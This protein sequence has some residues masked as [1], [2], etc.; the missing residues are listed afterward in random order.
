MKWSTCVVAFSLT[1]A[2]VSHSA[3]VS[4]EL[5]DSTQGI[6]CDSE[7]AQSERLE[8]LLFDDVPSLMEDCGIGGLFNLCDML[9][10]FGGVV[11]DFLGNRCGGGG[12]GRGNSL[13]CDWGF[14][15]ESA[16][17][18]YRLFGYQSNDDKKDSFITQ[19]ANSENQSTLVAR[20]LAVLGVTPDKDDA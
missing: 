18:A 10:S 3:K 12:G 19:R 9:G 7:R 14:D 6:V 4:A 1:L 17:Q 13:F 20:R 5:V 8:R 11:S 2:M 15:L 16:R